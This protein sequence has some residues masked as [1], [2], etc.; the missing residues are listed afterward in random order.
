MENNLT[1]TGNISL[2]EFKPNYNISFQNHAGEK[3]GTLDFNTDKL[4]FTGDAEESAKVFIDFIAKYFAT[5]LEEERRAEREAC[6]N[7]AGVALLGADLG[8]AR[9]VDQAIRVWD[10]RWHSNP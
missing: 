7:R 2:A 6:A 1:Y 4:V 5:R 3:V 9:R 8:L 10:N